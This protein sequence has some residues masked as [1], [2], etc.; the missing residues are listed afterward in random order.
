MGAKHGL[1]YEFDQAYKLDTLAF[2]DMTSQD[3]GYAY[4]KVRYWDENGVQTDVAGI[5]MQRKTVK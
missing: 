3:T 5:S 4:A 1:I 2:H